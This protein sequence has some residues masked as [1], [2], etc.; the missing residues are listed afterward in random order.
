MI[1]KERLK[2][3]RDELNIK[4]EIIAKHLNIATSTYST[5]ETEYQIMT[6]RLLIETCDYFNISLDYIFCFNSIKQYKNSKKAYDKRIIGKRLKEFRK[7]NNINQT[8]LADELST[9]FSVIS[10]YETGRRLIPTQFLYEICRLYNISADYL[11]GKIDEPKYL[12]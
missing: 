7:D 3:I 2:S 11:L 4:Q 6:L 10:G 9:T 5:Y 12:K 8:T 1:Y